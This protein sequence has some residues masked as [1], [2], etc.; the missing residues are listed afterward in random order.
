MRAV[1]L[2]SLSL[3]CNLASA[4]SNQV[5]RSVYGAP[6]GHADSAESVAFDE[7][8][9]TFVTGSAYSSATAT[10][11]AHVVAYSPSGAQVW[12]W[13]DRV[14]GESEQ[15]HVIKRSAKHGLFVMS[16]VGRVGT[17]LMR[18][19]RLDS[20][21]SL[22]FKADIDLG[23]P[24]TFT[25]SPD[26]TLDGEG[27][28]YICGRKGGSY[29]IA[30]FDSEGT[31]IWERTIPF[32]SSTGLATSIA[33][34]GLGNVFVT[35]VV[36]QFGGCVTYKLDPQGNPLWSHTELGNH[37]APLGPAILKLS[38]AGEAYVLASPESSF[39]VPKYQIWKL[40]AAG[41]RLWLN[42]YSQVLQQDAAALDFALDSKENTYVAAHRLTNGTAM[43][44][45]KYDKF[46]VRQWE[47]NWVGGGTRP[48]GVGLDIADNPAV[49]CRTG[50]ST[51]NGLIIGYDRSGNQLWARTYTGDSYNTFVSGGRFGYF[52]AGQTPNGTTDWV[53][54]RIESVPNR[55]IRN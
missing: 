35:G 41:Q 25:F 1:S 38:L 37:G 19:T 50:S 40:S 2:L 51:S 36:W 47:R 13:E 39:G 46:G 11:D 42:D 23:A 12:R 33:V 16:V 6:S 43:M 34:D 9:N 10:Y 55:G 5:F 7:F 22:I 3:L 21:G 15:P 4:Q 54:M 26:M 32:G 53:T 27:N 29:L 48:I 28:A 31:P 52:V 8:G 14:S 17:T 49:G 24:T 30:K 18:L 20:S 44:L 45:V